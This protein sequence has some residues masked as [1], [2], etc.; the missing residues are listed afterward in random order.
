MSAPVASETRSPFRASR[1]ISA[2]SADGPSPAT[3]KA[4]SSLRAQRDG[5]GLVIHPRTADVRGG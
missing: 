1:E 2:R 4:P 3:S 5:A